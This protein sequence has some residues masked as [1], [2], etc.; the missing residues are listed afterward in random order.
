MTLHFERRGAGRPLLLVHGLGGTVRSWDPIAPTLAASRELVLIDLPGHGR[1]PALAGPQTIA[2]FADAIEN[3]I[4]QQGLRGVDLVGSSVGAR[5]VLELSRRGL[6][7]H[8][9]A[10]DPGG[11]WQGWETTFFHYTL[12]ASIRLLRLLRPALPFLSRHALTRTLLLVQLS[13]RPWALPADVVL[14]ELRSLVATPVFDAMLRELAHGPL[15]PGSASTPGR[16]TI[17]WGRQDRLLLPR[18]AQRAQAAFPSARL[19]WFDDCGHFPQWD[20]PAETVRVIL[21]TCA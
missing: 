8:C 7:T 4:A 11:F 3:F 20:R 5:L 18:Q 13:A 9:V 19:H 17:G 14:T 12:A 21:E 1:S 16:M 15:Q 6:G 2:A 10:L